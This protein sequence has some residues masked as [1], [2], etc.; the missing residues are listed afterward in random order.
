MGNAVGAPDKG[1][2]AVDDTARNGTEIDI[3]EYLRIRGDQIQHALHWNGY[4][5]SHRSLGQH[6]RMPGL[7]NG[8]HTVGCEWTPERYVFYVD[9]VRTFETSQAI[10]QTP[11]YLIL[12][13]E[14][15]SWPGDIARAKL[16]DQVVFDYVRVWQKP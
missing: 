15:S 5:A 16:P 3:F 4:G 9:G 13:G 2:G 8:F 12:S 1:K 11:E 14:V 10:S 7:M 6:P